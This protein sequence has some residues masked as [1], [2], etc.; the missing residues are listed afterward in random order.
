MSLPRQLNLLPA[1]A[2]CFVQLIKNSSFKILQPYNLNF[3]MCVSKHFNVFQ[4]TWQHFSVAF[5]TCGRPFKYSTKL[6]RFLT[7][8]TRIGIETMFYALFQLQS[9]HDLLL[10][11]FYK[12][13]Y[14]ECKVS[15]F[16][17]ILVRI[18]PHLDSCRR[19]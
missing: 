16:G 7:N 19:K 17:V 6:L 4:I 8:H 1:S 5:I 14:T 3:W 11:T 13:L 9:F 12:D 2:L 10:T 18:F 15:V